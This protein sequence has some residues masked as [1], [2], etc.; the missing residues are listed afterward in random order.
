MNFV[1]IVSRTRKS[2][3]RQ[4]EDRA[5]PDQYLGSLSTLEEL[6]RVQ[7]WEGVTREPVSQ[8]PSSP[9]FIVVLE[10]PHK[11][12]YEGTPGPAKG[13]TGRAIARWLRDV[14]GAIDG[15]ADY[16]VIVVNAVQYQCS[17]GCITSKHRDTLFKAVWESSGEADFRKRLAGVHREGDIVICCCTKGRTNPPL[18]E[19]V[20]KAIKATLPEARVLTRYHPAS[21]WRN[22]NLRAPVDWHLSA[23]NVNGP[24]N[25]TQSS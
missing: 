10:S 18:R 12:E 5:C 15:N 22:R 8:R 16:S 20:F 9:A 3:I 2:H 24:S 6:L 13:A 14:V 21:W 4:P 19:M 11:D 1:D 17:L 25:Q 7:N 23:W